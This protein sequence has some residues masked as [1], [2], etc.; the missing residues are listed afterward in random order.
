MFVCYILDKRASLCSTGRGIV[1]PSQNSRSCSN[2]E[3]KMS[4]Q[5]T[6]DVRV[7]VFRVP[8]NLKM[9]QEQCLRVQV[10]R[11]LVLVYVRIHVCV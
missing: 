6:R 3:A 10:G 11:G 1:F 7:Q 5:R 2:S 8:V 9:T 4:N